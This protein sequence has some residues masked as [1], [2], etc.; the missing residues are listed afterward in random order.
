MTKRYLAVVW[1]FVSVSAGLWAQE[2]GSIQGRVVDP[3]GAAVP[4]VKVTI[5]QVGT[6]I[7]RSN[8]TSSEGLYSFANVAVGSYNVTAEASGFKKVAV[9][10]VKVE[11]AQRVLLDLNLE[12]GTLAETVEV[13]A[14]PPQLQTSD[15]QIGAVV[16]SK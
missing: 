13:T 5:E 15:S 14:A 1:L 3:Q 16:E 2:A 9:P 10:N 6:Q 4:A 7:A 11:V 8:T 12:I